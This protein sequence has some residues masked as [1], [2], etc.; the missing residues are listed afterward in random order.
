MVRDEGPLT[1]DFLDIALQLTD[2]PRLRELL[3]RT[4]VDTE[5]TYDACGI[6]RPF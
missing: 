1:M 3:A 4:L 5:Q 6:N 2:R